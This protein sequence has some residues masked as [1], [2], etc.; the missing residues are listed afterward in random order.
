MNSMR[1]LFLAKNARLLIQ[2]NNIQRVAMSNSI[3]QA[4][5]NAATMPYVVGHD[6]AKKEFYIKIR[7]EDGANSEDKALLQYDIIRDGFYDLYHTEVPPVF[8]GKGIAKL[9]AKAAFDFVVEQDAKM[10]LSCTYLQKYLEDN[11][12]PQYYSRNVPVGK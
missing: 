7:S 11:K 1:P 9:L 12:L 4:E 3:S 8:R 6:K 5:A 2:A 10:R